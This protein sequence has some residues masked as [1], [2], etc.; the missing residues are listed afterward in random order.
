[1]NANVV[2][3]ELREGRPPHDPELLEQL[4]VGIDAVHNFLCLQYLDSYIP[5]G[6]SKVKLLVGRE[7]CGKTHH[8]RL[9][10]HS[11]S[12]KGYLVAFID[13]RDIR[14]QHFNSLF[15]SIATLI[16]L[17]GMVSRYCSLVI[18]A[19]GYEP[20][21]IPEGI[22]FVDWLMKDRGR[23]VEVVK[24]EVREEVQKLLHNRRIEATFGTAFMQL[25]SDQLGDLSLSGESKEVLFK[26]IAGEPIPLLQLRPLYIFTRVDRYNARNMLRSI[27]EIARL[28]GL[29]GLLVCID[30]LEELL[31]DDPKTG[32]PKYT[33]PARD[34]AYESIRE[35]IDDID[36]LERVMFIMTGR[37]EL[38]DDDVRG[39]R[40]YEAL[41][42]RL[43]DE[44]S[45]DKPNYFADLL[46][47]DR[48]IRPSKVDLLTLGGKL[49]ELC[50]KLTPDFDKSPIDLERLVEEIISQTSSISPLR[51]LVQAV[52]GH[53]QNLS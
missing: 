3:G 36:N 7:G 49:I 20:E 28:V 53:S 29:S 40:S 52:V 32:R 6:G 42:L 37:L 4:T 11:A 48:V 18:R 15:S 30:N 39:V 38:V 44:I 27:L 31:A 14:L 46:Y 26:W 21:Q 25:C 13:A 12:Q 1:M 23:V 41:W 33:R 45:S 24:R 16:G 34:D 17:G 47:L 2:L 51:R 19:L 10:A 22:K 8:L 43:Q 50:Q 35:L 9:L 5:A